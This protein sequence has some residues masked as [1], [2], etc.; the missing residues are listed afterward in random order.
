MRTDYLEDIVVVG[1]GQF[2]VCLG[3][4]CIHLGTAERLG[5]IVILSA[6]EKIEPKQLAYCQITI[7]EPLPASLTLM[8]FRFA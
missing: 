6:A 4:N 3:M 8:P 1:Q 7:A 5:K 2:A